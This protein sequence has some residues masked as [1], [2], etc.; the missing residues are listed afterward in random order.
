M[1]P[2]HDALSQFADE[3]FRRHYGHLPAAAAMAPGRVN[4][5]G[6][7]TDY[8]GGLVLPTI[9]ESRIEVRLGPSHTKQ[10]HYVSTPVDT[11]T[12]TLAPDT[13]IRRTPAARPRKDWSDYVAAMLDQLRHHHGSTTPFNVQIAGDLPQAAGVSSSAALMVALGRAYRT[14]AGSDLTDTDIARLAQRAENDF[15]GVPCGIMDQMAVAIG[16]C[17]H[18]LCLATD[19]LD[20]RHIPLLHRHRFITIHSGIRRQLVAGHYQQRRTE[21]AAA[22]RALDVTALCHASLQQL[23]NSDIADQLIGRRARHVIT[24][25]RRVQAMA[26]ALEAGDAERCG[27]LLTQGHQSLRHDFATSLPAIDRL[28]DAAIEAGALGARMTGGG[29]GGC[30]VALVADNHLQAF[31]ARIA[32]DFPDTNIIN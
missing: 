14:L 25:H 6:E 29:F 20:H 13:I 7:H 32:R 11:P 2:P 9:L 24:D 18:A 31:Q 3:S 28:T 23:E 1:I 16:R 10:D 5:I 26:Q 19:T 12:G 17:G 27:T 21:C 4:L 8:N 15:V 22:A 30:I